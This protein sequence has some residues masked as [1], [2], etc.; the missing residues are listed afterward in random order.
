MGTNPFEDVG[1]DVAE[2]PG[3]LGAVHLEAPAAV[4]VLRVQ[5]EVLEHRPDVQQFG[6]GAPEEMGSDADKS[7]ITRKR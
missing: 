6:V 1:L 7:A 5:A 2:G 4:A 3:L